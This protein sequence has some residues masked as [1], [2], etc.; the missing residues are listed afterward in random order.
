MYVVKHIL[1][2][3][4]IYHLAFIFIFKVTN[5]SNIN[6]TGI[7]TIKNTLRSFSITLYIHVSTSTMRCHQT[8][9]AQQ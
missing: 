9:T 2:N 7:T 6:N 1:K 5:V 3:H 4:E 8:T